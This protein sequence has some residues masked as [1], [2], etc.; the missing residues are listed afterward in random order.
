MRFSGLMKPRLNCMASIL[1]IMSRGNRAP[2][3]TCLIPPRRWSMV[4]AGT[5]GPGV[6]GKL[7]GEKYRDIL[8]VVLKHLVQSTQNIRLED[9]RNI[10][11]FLNGQQG[12][13]KP[14][15]IENVRIPVMYCRMRGKE[16]TEDRWERGM[17]DANLA[18]LNTNWQGRIHIYLNH[19]KSQ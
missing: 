8:T 2:L 6:E 1:S 18:K 10:R 7:N 3:I 17:R 14:S 15:V 11:S 19:D 4:R 5:G 9:W 13:L 12:A 16:V